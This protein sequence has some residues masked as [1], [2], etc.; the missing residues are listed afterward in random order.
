MSRSLLP[1]ILVTTGLL[2]T[3]GSQVA[4]A[5]TMA[6]PTQ[7]E[8]SIPESKPQEALTT[9]QPQEHSATSAVVEPAT[10]V[11]DWMAQIEAAEPQN[12]VQITQ[13]QVNPT[14]SGLEILLVT[15]DN[16][17]LAV[18]VQQFRSS[19]NSLIAEIDNAVLNL[20]GQAFQAEDPA[21]DIDRISVTQLE[22]NRLRVEVA[23]TTG[24]PQTA[25]TLKTNGQ[26]YSLQPN[27]DEIGEEVEITVTAEQEQEA[28]YRVPD[29]TTATKT[30]TPLRDIPQ[31]IQIVPKEV[32]QDRKVNR[33]VEALENVSG[34]TSNSGTYRVIDNFIIRGF[35]A[36]TNVT[37]NGL[38]DL[39][40]NFPGASANNLE[41]I[42]V[43]K[44]PASVLYGQGGAG[45]I[46]NLVTKQPLS[47]PF[48]SA[49]V[50]VGSFSTYEPSFDITGPFNADKTVL[51]RL[52]GSYLNAKSFIDFFETERVSIAPTIQWKIS[53]NTT[54]TFEAE[55]LRN[56][57]SNNFG[58]PAV[59]TVLPNPNGEVPISRTV[60][61]PDD[62]IDINLTRLGYTFE[63]RFN[64][65]WSLRNAFGATLSEFD[66]K[67]VFPFALQAD[68]R[69]VDRSEGLRQASNNYFNLVTDVT[70]KFKTGS[71][72][73]QL[74]IGFDLFKQDNDENF[75]SRP[76]ASIDLFNPV[77][78]AI[79]DPPDFV[80]RTLEVSESLGFY[81]Q[82]QITILDNLKFLI[83][84]RFDLTRQ[85]ITDLLDPTASSE[86]SNS[87]FSPR[88]GI[89]YQ[90]IQPISL[91]ASFTR[92]FNPVAGRD[93]NNT[94]FQPERGTQYEVG[95]KADITQKLSATLAFYQLT[96][97]NVETDDPINPDFSIQTGEQRSRGIEFDLSGEILPGWK[98]ITSYAYTD[99]H[100][101]KDTTFPVGNLIDNVPQHSASLWS[102]YEIQKGAVKGLGFGLGLYYVGD[103]AGDLDNTFVL[104]S[105]LRTDASI[106]YRQSNW[107]I[108]LNFRNLFGANYFEGANNSGF[109][110]PGSP[111]TITGSISVE[112]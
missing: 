109:V 13:V 73:H 59:G 91:Y 41:Q 85:K 98:V 16:Q 58:L 40:N 4:P 37:R 2:S 74:L 12:L 105:Y 78:G 25:V 87:A 32:I 69:T 43:L 23:G 84:G 51:Y 53:K 36:S 83:G 30:D 21:S 97:T 46:I 10:T 107:R 100:I 102:T 1:V 38:R 99:A 26:V 56:S 57:N 18:D 33:V 60:S 108:G 22:E 104:P 76:I 71:V 106:F 82:D 110:F 111:R 72:Q 61:E 94:V 28:G 47:D 62:F 93:F 8:P 96:R 3:L 11:K 54:F 81:A 29:A 70:G 20:P 5:Q 39:T 88:L 67:Q 55:Y 7:L 66:Q 44:G 103:R 42:E 45:G 49:E 31:S 52:N 27:E 77:Y 90:P 34:V 79:P 89:V 50:S 24:V 35:D 101:T 15:Q 48:Y 86:Q 112:F 92:S 95:V 68:N 17:S 65:N 6:K 9:V 80:S 63:H 75:E 64:E 14:D 19:G